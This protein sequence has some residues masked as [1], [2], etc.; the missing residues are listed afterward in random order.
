MNGTKESSQTMTGTGTKASS[1]VPMFQPVPDATKPGAGVASPTL[2]LTSETSSSSNTS[3]KKEVS[4]SAPITKELKLMKKLNEATVAKT[5][6][7][8]QVTQ[9]A[10]QMT[11]MTKQD[12]QDKSDWMALIDISQK[13]GAERAMEWAKEK[14]GNGDFTR[15]NGVRPLWQ[16][17][18]DEED[19]S[20]LRGRTSTRNSGR[21]QRL[22]SPSPIK[23][24]TR[25]DN[26]LLDLN[27]ASQAVEAVE[28]VYSSKLAKFIIRKPYGGNETMICTYLE[29][30]YD[31]TVPWIQEVNIYLKNANVE[32]ESTLE[33]VSKIIADGSILILHGSSN[34]RHGTVIMGDDGHINGYEW[35]EFGDIDRRNEPLGRVMYIDSEGNDG[36]YWLDSVYEE[37]LKIREVY[38]KSV[39]SAAVA[40]K[41]TSTNGSQSPGYS[42]M[43]V[44]HVLTPEKVSKSKSKEPSPDGKIS[45]DTMKPEMIDVCVGTDDLQLDDADSLKKKTSPPTGRA[46]VDEKRDKSESFHEGNEDSGSTDVLSSFIIFFFSSIFNLAW[47][48]LIRMPLRF[49]LHGLKMVIF[50][51]ILYISWLYMANDN[52][53]HTMGAGVKFSLMNPHGIH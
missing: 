15:R 26:P 36:E 5:N 22:K 9:L 12:D 7:L 4:Q 11:G 18:S 19:E 33:V 6:S 30:E 31:E 25:E 48:V 50:S 45:E 40:L 38:C 27:I 23:R 24:K 16:S 42:K 41:T 43:T 2:P 52:G 51:V 29:D 1:S 47:F 3:K 14:L 49:V 37:A 13:E 32:M 34:V 8:R 10:H 46:P 28:D 35:R 20:V 17:T 39:F 53:A 21:R 44:P